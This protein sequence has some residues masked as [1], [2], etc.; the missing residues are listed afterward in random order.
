MNGINSAQKDPSSFFSVQPT[1]GSGNNIGKIQ[2][3]FDN[4]QLPSKQI[5][6]IFSTQVHIS[7]NRGS[8]G[9]RTNSLLR[10]NELLVDRRTAIE[11]DVS[12]L[13]D[14]DLAALVTLSLIHI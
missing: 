5:D 12:D 8:V 1:D 13:N 9:A 2:K 7:N 10:Q 3:L 6:N 14:A 11:K 4:N